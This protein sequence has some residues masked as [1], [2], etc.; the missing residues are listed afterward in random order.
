M[1]LHWSILILPIFWAAVAP[2]SNLAISN[3]DDTARNLTA[4]PMASK[5][6][7]TQPLVDLRRERV[8]P[9]HVFNASNLCLQLHLNHVVTWALAQSWNIA[10]SLTSPQIESWTLLVRRLSCQ[11]I[12]FCL[13]PYIPLCCSQCPR[14]DSNHFNNYFINTAHIKQPTVPPP[15]LTSV[16]SPSNWGHNNRRPRW[17]RSLDSTTHDSKLLDHR[18]Q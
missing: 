15:V 9:R 14:P 18:L 16:H 5:Q 11:L 3:F 1:Y 10:S 4:Q 2:S 12:Y 13:N 6:S 8:A 7:S 17:G